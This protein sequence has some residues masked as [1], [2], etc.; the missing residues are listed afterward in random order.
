MRIG[1]M[2]SA[3]GVRRETGE[4]ISYAE[5]VRRCA[6]A[7]FEVMDIN[8]CGLHRGPGVLREDNWRKVAEDIR[9][10]AEKC[11]VR[12]V[13]SHLPYRSMSMQCDLDLFKTAEGAELYRELSLRAIEIT[14]ILGGKWAVIHPMNDREAVVGDNEAHIKYNLRIL[15]REIDLCHKLNVG[16]AFENIFDQHHLRRF[17]MRA[18]E[19]KQFIDYCNDPLIEACWDVGHGNITMERQAEGIRVL[20][21]HIKA[22]HIHDNNGRDD[23]H[24]MPFTGTVQW[25]EIM[26]AM[27]ESGCEADL[28]LE[29]GFSGMPDPLKDE[30]LKTSVSICKHL[31]SLYQ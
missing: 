4:K 28:I 18:M 9:N 12:F 16:L 24:A 6:D 15:D 7:G 29:T 21:K 5:A 8:L 13:Q 14:H 22:L 20:G 10:E 25:E 27:Y 26:H 17:G 11:G 3:L 30:A 2:T 19:L 1:N 23:L 31:I